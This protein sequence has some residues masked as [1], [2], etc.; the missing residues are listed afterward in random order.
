[1]AL[2]SGR[3]CASGS[4]TRMPVEFVLLLQGERSQFHLIFPQ[5]MKGFMGFLC[6]AAAD[7]F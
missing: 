6:S 2:T 4:N 1:M 5:A 7:L 3:D